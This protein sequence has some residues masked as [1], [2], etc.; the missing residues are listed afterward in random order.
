M[1]QM[2]RRIFDTLDSRHSRSRATHAVQCSII[3]LI[4]LNVVVA[5]IDTV[6]GIHSQFT[7]FFGAFEALSVIVFSVEYLLRLW[8]CVEDKRYDDHP[9]T[10]RLKFM[11]SPMALIDL[12]AIMPFYFPI[13]FHHTDLLFLRT[14]RLFRLFRILKLERYSESL[15]M[16]AGVLK[17]RKEELLVA[18]LGVVVLVVLSSGL[19]YLTEHDAQPKQFSS[20]PQAM[21]WSVCT[22]TTIGYGD[23]TPITPAGK[24]LASLISF[25]GI[26]MVAVPTAI[27]S[28]GFIEE[29]QHRKEITKVCPHCGK[30]LE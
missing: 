11:L 15:H 23:V 4:L 22:L 8:T 3:V 5:V 19:L 9:V 7:H 17:R 20:V 2:R 18:A 26:A 29:I 30:E 16:F 12:V 13:V 21:W 6:E 25:I 28:A 14:V 27:L 24:F 10:G 1:S